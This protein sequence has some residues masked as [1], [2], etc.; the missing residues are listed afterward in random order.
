MTAC[1]F[2]AIRDGRAP[3]VVIAEEARSLAIMDRNPLNDGHVL[4]IPRVHAGSLFEIAEADLL[5]AAS[6]ARRL[7]L[8]IRHSLAPDGL[9]LL[10]NSGGAA[11]QSVPHFHFHLIPRWT[12]DGKGFDWPLVPGDPARLHAQAERIRRA[13]ANPA[14]DP[15]RPWAV[16]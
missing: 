9:H 3:A 11:L 5:A 7:A 4:V 16:E 14:P 8:A 10:Q 2:C 15:D 12:G 1:I 13:L 6:L